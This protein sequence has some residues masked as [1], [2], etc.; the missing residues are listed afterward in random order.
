MDIHVKTDGAVAYGVD[1]K[2][3]DVAVAGIEYLLAYGFKQSIGD[4]GTS[5]AAKAMADW[6]KARKDAT[7]T[8]PSKAEV[9]AWKESAEGKATIEAAVTAAQLKRRDAIRDGT[10]AVREGGYNRLSPFERFCNETAETEGRAKAKARGAKWPTDKDEE[11]ALV[12][13][14]VALRLDEYT[15]AFARLG[16]STDGLDDL[17]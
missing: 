1:V 3:T 17:F 11:A 10:V 8:T 16:K 14:I 5:A 9:D 12:A 13:K 15:K 6:A 4:A 7:G 2:W